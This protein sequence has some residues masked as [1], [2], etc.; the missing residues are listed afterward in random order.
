VSVT[1]SSGIPEG[2]RRSQGRVSQTYLEGITAVSEGAG[3][4]VVTVTVW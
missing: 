2:P 3:T 1:V 4:V